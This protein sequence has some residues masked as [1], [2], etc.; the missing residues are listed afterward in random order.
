MP[1]TPPP[2]QPSAPLPPPLPRSTSR[3]GAPFGDDT[4]PLIPGAASGE[5]EARRIDA[6]LS[7][8]TRPVYVLAAAALLILLI[9]FLLPPATERW[10]RPVFHRAITDIRDAH[11]QHWRPDPPYSVAPQTIGD[12][13]DDYD[14]QVRIWARR[15]ERQRAENREAADAVR[16]VVYGVP[17]LLIGILITVSV[18]WVFAGRPAVRNTLVVLPGLGVIAVVIQF[19]SWPPLSPVAAVI[20]VIALSIPGCLLLAA[21]PRRRVGAAMIL[22][23]YISIGCIV[24][25]AGMALE[26]NESWQSVA[27]RVGVMAGA[28]ASS[29]AGFAALGLAVASMPMRFIVPGSLSSRLINGIPC[30]FCL[31]VLGL[32][33]V[34]T[35]GPEILT[36]IC[37][38]GFLIVGAV[39]V[40]RH[41]FERAAALVQL[42]LLVA[43]VAS[44]P[45]VRAMRGWLEAPERDDVD[46]IF[47]TVAI[48]A[49][50][51]AAMLDLMGSWHRR[52]AAGRDGS[53]FRALAV[54]RT[55]SAP[56]IPFAEADR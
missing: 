44:A 17:L 29:V 25:S 11:G 26:A 35:N 31:V 42:G 24:W 47:I 12:T 18:L 36:V 5:A 19:L 53:T 40:F 34:R 30:A 39:N 14:H 38:G 55:P 52:I 28:A 23:G 45:I 33:G 9:N 2:L 41:R 50:L 56:A 8:W 54:R 43:T 6:A 10:D 7:R 15:T 27:G 21:M 3:S 46:V 51:I 37:L 49:F 32:S 1:P 20:S 13:D 48:S 22:G 4:G 16:P